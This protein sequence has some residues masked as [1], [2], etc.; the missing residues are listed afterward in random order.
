[1]MSCAWRSL[2]TLKITRAP[3]LSC[4][5]P[6]A[7]SRPLACSSPN[8]SRWAGRAARRAGSSVKDSSIQIT[9]DRLGR[10]SLTVLYRQI[11]GR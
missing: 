4:H 2:S 8:R 9:G 11:L 7:S 3:V 6:A 1:M 10:G 5:G